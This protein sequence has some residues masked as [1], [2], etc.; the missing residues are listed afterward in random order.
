MEAHVTHLKKQ[1][2]VYKVFTLEQEIKLEQEQE[3]EVYPDCSWVYS[4]IA[5]KKTKGTFGLLRKD[6]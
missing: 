1:K 3:Q 6:F 2:Y 4:L 5:Q